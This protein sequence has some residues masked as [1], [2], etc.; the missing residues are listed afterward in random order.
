M[1]RYKLRFYVASGPNKGNLDHEE[2]IDSIEEL[3]KTYKELFANKPYSLR[4]TAYEWNGNDW[5]RIMGYE[6]RCY[7]VI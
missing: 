2:F 1:K 6:W 5:I 4:P 7:N 3:D